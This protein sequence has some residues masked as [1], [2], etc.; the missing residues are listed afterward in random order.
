MIDNIKTF[1]EGGLYWYNMAIKFNEKEF[2]MFNWGKKRE[3]KSGV[4]EKQ[5]SYMMAV[6][7][8][9]DD[10]KDPDEIIKRLKES[11]LFITEKT[12]V[13]SVIKAQVLYLGK[14]Y[15][16]DI[17]PE[18]YEL[19]PMYTINHHLTEENYGILENSRMGLTVAMTFSDDILESYHLQLKIL[20]CI[21]PDMAAAIDFCSEKVLSGVWIRLAAESSIAPS[22]DYIY[23]IQAVSGEKGEVWLHSHGLHRCGAIEVEI[24]NSDKDNYN[25]HYYI[26]QTLA[27]RIISNNTFIDE[28]DSIWAG[29][30]NN[31][32]DIV[33][34]W[35][36]FKEAVK[37][38]PKNLT[39]GVNDRKE[40][41][42]KDTGVVYLYLCEDDFNKKK[43]TH[44]SAINEYITDNLLMM[45]TNEET[46]RMAA[47][48]KD[49][50]Q[51]FINAIKDSEIE[52]LMKIG[53]EVDEE[54]KNEDD[55]F[56][57]HIW[58]HVLDINEDNIHAVLTQE[59]YYIKDLKADTEMDV[60]LK[61]LT[62]WILYTPKGQVTPDSIYL[63]E[64]EN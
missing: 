64:M 32:D 13:D 34:T 27:K 38:Y 62:D 2:F 39:G 59:P 12:E 28:E 17:I 5:I 61:D 50:V 31:G 37:K 49:R 51:Y 26:L 11:E 24:L 18:N 44:V 40:G 6:P 47:L 30:M 4:I 3:L 22:P 56:R 55:T 48:A 10:I 45:Y 14:S 46:A 43:Y 36:D 52:G 63:L 35:I 1:T 25:N 54:F 16:I 7:R 8:K 21:L 41:H 53:L 33:A 42:N 29:R 60:N 57:E 20:Y 23:T 19:S 15:N 9:E 58:F